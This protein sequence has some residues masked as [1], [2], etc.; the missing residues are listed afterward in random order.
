M[1]LGRNPQAALRVACRRPRPIGVLLAF[2]ALGCAPEGNADAELAGAA[3][4]AASFSVAD[5]GAQRESRPPVAELDLDEIGFVTGS[6]DAPINVVEFSDFGCGYCRRFHL[7]TYP[8]IRTEFID[9][10]V[11]RWRYVSYASGMFRHGL[12]AAVAAECAGEVGDEAFDAMRHLLYERQA[13]WKGE[14]EP[15][16]FF[17][18]AAVEAGA[19]RE[20][21][22]SCILEDRPKERLRSGLINAARSRVRGTPFFLIEGRPLVGAQPLQSWR[23]IFQLLLG[24]QDTAP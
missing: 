1:I 23:D 21:F 19:T 20:G 2:A 8:E 4:P 12:A 14:A 22:R 15:Y 9:A 3:D 7:E 13:S 16:D 6:A 10:G 24:E 11:V 17:E 18:N 5:L